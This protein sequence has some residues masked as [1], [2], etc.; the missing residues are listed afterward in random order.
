M[1][2]DK[3]AKLILKDG[4]E[5][6]GASF[7]AEKSVAGEVVFA[8]GMVGYPEALTDPSFKGQILVM[9]YPLVGNYGVP[10]KESWESPKIQIA[11]LVVCN[12]VDTPSHHAS[13]MTLGKWFK[14]EGV[15]F[16]QIKD[17]RALTQKLRSEGVGLGKIISGGKDIPFAD[18]NLKNLVAEVSTKKIMYF[19]PSAFGTS[20]YGRRRKGGDTENPQTIVLIDCGAK[21]NIIRRLIARGLKVAV[22]PWNTDIT[23]LRFPFSAVVISNG[24]GDPTKV[25]VTIDNVKKIIAKKIPVLGICLGNQILTLSQGGS[26]YKLKFGHRSQNQPA[27]LRTLAGKPGRAYLTTQ[28][29]GFAVGEIPKGFREWFYNANDKT[30]EGIIHQSRP[31]MSV[32]FHP[33][34]SPGPLDTDWVFDYF[35][36]KARIHL[37]PPSAPLSLPRRGEGGE[38]KYL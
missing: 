35:L 32:Q 31:I 9:T 5:I 6:K 4:T 38:V 30:N 27:V 2:K 26:T 22:V 19:T 14:K 21:Q 16:I 18:P 12:Y 36:K 37:T 20:P 24:P 7:G 34:S 13:E 23:K 15:P 17:T 28:N 29:H 8:T 33:E 25:K 1:T 3:L 10:K 11:G